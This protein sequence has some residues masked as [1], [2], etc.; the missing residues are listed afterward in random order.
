MLLKKFEIESYRGIKR[1][2]LDLDRSTVLIGENN[3]G[4]TSVLDALDT[5]MN[6]GLT[7]RASPFSEYD[8][9]LA[10]GDADPENAPP[11]TLT[12]TFEETEFNEW[13]DEIDQIFDNV[14]QLLDD[15][16]RQL[17][18]QVSSS[19]EKSL[20]DFTVEWCF[21][22]RNRNPLTTAK[23]PRLVADLQSLAPV[24]L[25]GALRDASQQFHSKAPFWAP[26]IKNPQLGDEQRESIE[27]QI[28]QINQAVLDSHRPFDVVKDRLA[29][30]GRLIPL[31]SKDLVSVEAVPSRIQDM[32]A[33]TQVKLAC[34]SG[35]R[36]PLFRHGEGTQSTAV[37]FLFEAF[38]ESRLAEAYGKNSEPILALEEPE[39][40]LHPSAI[41]AL[42]ST[43]DKFTG[44]KIISTHS[45]DLLSAVPLGAIRRLAR[46]GDKVEVFKVKDCTL[47]SRELEQI[48]FHIRAKRGS[49]LFARCWLLVE[50][51]SE[52][53]VV[54]E[55]ARHLGIDFEYEGVSCIDFAQCPLPPLIK[56]ADDLGIQ[57]HL[58][59]DGDTQGQRNRDNA[60]SFLGSRPEADHITMIPEPDL[61]HHFWTEGYMSVYENTA[62]PRDKKQHV[63]APK[64]TSDYVTQTVKAAIATAG[65]KPP[66][67]L[68]VLT[69]VLKSG[70]NGVPGSICTAVNK[71]A[72]L[73]RGPE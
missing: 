16:R 50:G 26:F 59:T 36:L 44:Q 30:V 43:L 61:E 57:W 6:R 54:P 24:F 10:T 28:G 33:R 5:C 1:L 11:I 32:L 37:L 65:G 51:E 70:P 42:W 19:Y 60:R 41:R 67:A 18:F 29:Q 40:H 64:G 22:D 14:I 7:R 46:R 38:L 27:E 62:S 53:L 68:A 9:H 17:T 58:L 34:H 45:G 56:V 39:S 69:E 25:L 47:N 31:S 49:L 13:A 12:L 52:F 71:A 8:F 23:Q 3:I 35:A 15:G 72:T 48:Q 2:D 4:K 55:M 20:R 63:T 73:A 66:L 21:L